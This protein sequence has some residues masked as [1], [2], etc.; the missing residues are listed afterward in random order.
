MVSCLNVQARKITARFL[1]MKA[2]WAFP[3]SENPQ[4]GHHFFQDKPQKNS[5][6]QI[7]ALRFHTHEGG[8]EVGQA[9]IKHGLGMGLDSLTHG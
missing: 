9:G 2:T 8:C 7:E 3:L 6:H 1:I 4:M 5:I